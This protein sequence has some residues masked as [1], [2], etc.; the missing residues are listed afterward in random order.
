MPRV[1]KKIINMYK[2]LMDLETTHFFNRNQFGFL[3]TH[4]EKTKNYNKVIRANSVISEKNCNLNT[5]SETKICIRLCRR[6]VHQSK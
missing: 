5:R 2:Q 1:L 6:Q 4:S 3:K